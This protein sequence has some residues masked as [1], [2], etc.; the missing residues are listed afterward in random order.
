MIACSS[1]TLVTIKDI[2]VLLGAGWKS[3][4]AARSQRSAICCTVTA[5]EG[6]SENS[7]RVAPKM[8]ER[9]TARFRSR[10]RRAPSRLARSPPSGRTPARGPKLKRPRLLPYSD[11]ARLQGG[12]GTQ[13][14]SPVRNVVEF[15]FNV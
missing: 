12:L 9:L 5:P 10:R 15:R 2:S 6:L 14:G 4:P 1:I 3:V 13:D 7:T 8:A 11:C